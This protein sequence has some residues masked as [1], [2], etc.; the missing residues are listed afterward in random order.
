MRNKY[1]TEAEWVACTDPTPM[2]EYLR[3]KASDRKLRLFA[4]ACCRRIWHVL[5]DERSRKAIEASERFA[6]R[7]ITPGQLMA[8][9]GAAQKVALKVLNPG[10]SDAALVEAVQAAHEVAKSAQTIPTR[11]HLMTYIP[12]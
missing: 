11:A 1:M 2:L 10:S 8:A 5:N 6:D 3:G 9:C 7:L 4:C 12:R